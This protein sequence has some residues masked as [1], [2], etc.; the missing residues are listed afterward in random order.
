MNLDS[1]DSRKWYFLAALGICVLFSFI[2]YAPTLNS[3]FI[4]EDLKHLNFDWKEVRAEFL[5]PAQ[6]MGYRPGSTLYMVISNKIWGRNPVGHHSA[7][8][9]I[10]ALTGWLVGMTA[11]RMTK[12]Y[13]MAFM[14]ALIFI[15]APAQMEPVIW[16]AAAIGTVTSTFFCALAMLIWVKSDTSQSHLSIG[17]ASFLYLIAILFK[18]FALTLPGLLIVIDWAMQRRFR[19]LTFKSLV[20][21]FFYYWPFLLVLVIYAFLYWNSNAFQSAIA[22]GASGSLNLLFILG[23]F[24]FSVHDLLLPLGNY[25]DLDSGSGYLFWI[26]VLG[27]FIWLSRMRWTF[28]LAFVALLPGLLVAGGRMTYLAMVGFSMGIS[29][30]LYDLVNWVSK[31]TKPKNFYPSLISLMVILISAY[32]IDVYRTSSIFIEAGEVGWNIPRQA[33]ALVPELPPN[34]ELY[35]IG[36][37]ENATFRWGLPY[38]I[39]HVY[40]DNDLPIFMVVDGPK[41]WDKISLQSISCDTDKR[42]FFFRYSEEEKR[43]SLVSTKEFGISCQ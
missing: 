22:Y 20:N 14:A 31:K 28:V 38:E 21:S 16:L 13:V 12:N 33:K 30:L 36:F 23:R 6:S 35:F 37:P 42:R 2:L 9:F 29:A 34:A 43:I 1:F 24:S 4:A 11:F 40:A 41:A 5:T 8:V 18:E 32:A 25:I 7:I 39:R 27:V 17:F 10:H 3:Y 26:V 19:S 15:G